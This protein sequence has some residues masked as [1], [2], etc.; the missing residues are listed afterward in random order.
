MLNEFREDLVSGEWVLFAT[1]RAKRSGT[2]PELIPVAEPKEICPFED[3]EKSGNVILATY[4]NRDKTDWFAKVV[5]NKF[6]AVL[7]GRPGPIRSEGPFY[8]LEARGKHE[9]IVFRDHDRTL[10]EYSSEELADI[11]K[12]YQERYAAMLDHG[13]MKYVLIFH[14]QG[15]RAGA[16]IYHPHSQMISIPILP[17][18]VRRSIRGSAKFYGENHMKVYDVMIDWEKTQA[19]RIVYE[20]KHFIAFCPFV[21][22]TPYEV[23]VFPKEGHAHFDQMSADR[24]IPLGEAMRAVLGGMKRALNNADYNF[25]IHT[26]PLE[27]SH[28]HNFYTWHIE[29]LPQTT[30][31]GG[32]DLGSGVEVNIIDP[33]EAAKILR[34]T[35]TE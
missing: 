5:K 15:P 11:F 26:A 34:G 9:I 21:S 4:P 32:F 10:A 20:N 31:L 33:D 12:I 25:F 2:R 23:R 8:T 19:K 1:G 6:P 7:E 3:L 35:G 13:N 28:A 27:G 29:I 30:I 22:K 18:D 24:L 16:T 17:P 14:N